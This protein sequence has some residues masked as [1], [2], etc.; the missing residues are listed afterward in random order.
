MSRYYFRSSLSSCKHFFFWWLKKKKKK[1]ILILNRLLC[2]FPPS[3]ANCSGNEK[4]KHL[5]ICLPM[6]K[7]TIAKLPYEIVLWGSKFQNKWRYLGAVTVLIFQCLLNL[8]VYWFFYCVCHQNYPRISFSEVEA[9]DASPWIIFHCPH[10][11]GPERGSTG[12]PLHLCCCW[13]R[14]LRHPQSTAHRGQVPTRKLFFLPKGDL[15]SVGLSLEIRYWARKK[16]WPS[17]RDRRRRAQLNRL[18]AFCWT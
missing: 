6:L 9:G 13:R 18:S 14:R 15:K 5:F 16:S 3:S 12:K 7:A 8:T 10:C 17:R 1:K 2:F 4:R 11:I